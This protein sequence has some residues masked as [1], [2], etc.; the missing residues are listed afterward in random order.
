[1]IFWKPEPERLTY[2]TGDARTDVPIHEKNLACIREWITKRG[3]AIAEL[4]S[5]IHSLV[6]SEAWCEALL[7][8]AREAAAR[9]E[10]TTE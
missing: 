6:E 7:D 10:V 5:Q 1:M 4:E 9:M 2:P 8:V 3:A